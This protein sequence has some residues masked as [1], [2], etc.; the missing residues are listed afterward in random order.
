MDKSDTGP[1][2]MLI[3]SVVD[4]RAEEI[5]GIEQIDMG[6]QRKCNTTKTSGLIAFASDKNQIEYHLFLILR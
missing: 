4:R 5:P 6:I 3:W 2:E 1:T